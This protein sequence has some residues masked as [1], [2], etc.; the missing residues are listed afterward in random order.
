VRAEV[1][2]ED[3]RT[4]LQASVENGL[5][6]EVEIT[7]PDEIRLYDEFRHF[8]GDGSRPPS[9]RPSSVGG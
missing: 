5:V 7:D 8:R 4:R 2:Y 1:R 3:Q 9:R 6:T